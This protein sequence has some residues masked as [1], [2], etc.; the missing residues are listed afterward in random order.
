MNERDISNYP[1]VLTTEEARLVLGIGKNA[2]YKILKSGELP[3]IRIGKL[4]RIPK[5]YLLGFLGSL[6]DNEIAS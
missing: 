4:Y 5:A 1:D 3:S 6:C 2:M